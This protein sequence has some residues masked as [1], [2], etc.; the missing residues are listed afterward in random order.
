MTVVW[1]PSWDYTI[2]KSN[3]SFDASEAIEHIIVH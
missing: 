2:V 1:N 3:G